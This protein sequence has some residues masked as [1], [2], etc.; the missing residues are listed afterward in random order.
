MDTLVR[1]KR[2]KTSTVVF[3]LVIVA[4]LAGGVYSI[5]K[6]R[7]ETRRKAQ[8]E[9]KLSG[10]VATFARRYNAIMGWEEDFLAAKKNL[11]SLKLEDTLVNTGGRPV[12]IDKPIYD[13]ARRGEKYFLYVYGPESTIRFILECNRELARRVADRALMSAEYAIVARIL[14][15]ER[16]E[17]KL[18]PGERGTDDEGEPLA[19]YEIEVDSSELFI[20]R[21]D[22]LDVFSAD[23]EQRAADLGK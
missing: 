13:V 12:L 17:L 1:S 3:A 8:Q 11:Y 19:A 4:G 7:A 2:P 14:T 16:A 23:E 10:E 18:V 21:G 9:T 6:D 20:A 15:V 22:C 5:L